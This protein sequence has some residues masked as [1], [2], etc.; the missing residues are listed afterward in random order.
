MRHF[1]VLD[2]G[3]LN[4]EIVQGL[5]HV[6]DEH[7]GLVRLFRTARDR[8]NAGK[9]PGFKIRL[10]NMGG[11]RG[12]ELPTSEILGGIVIESRPRS[13]TNFDVI[14]EFRGGPH[15][16]TNKLH[17]SY[18]SLQFPLLFVFGQPGFYPELTL[19]PYGGRG[20]GKSD[21]ERLLQISVTPMDKGI[22]AY[23]QG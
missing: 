22:Q 12:F 7:N 1:G 8:C 11:I 20:R 17:Q 9:I 13:Q 14:I 23:L 21:N 6:L 16:R 5:I 3:A 2:K 19:M 10:Y 15:Q 18:M 4:P